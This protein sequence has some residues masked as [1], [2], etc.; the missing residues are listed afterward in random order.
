METV[1]TTLSIIIPVRDPGGL[2]AAVHTCLGIAT[3]S[4][5]DHEIILVNDGGGRVVADAANQLAATHPTV[6]VIHHAQRRGYTFALRDGWSVAR[7]THIAAIDLAG[8]AD[9]ADLTRLLPY[10]HEAA[11]VLAYRTDGPGGPLAQ[12][13]AAV[14]RR[15]LSVELHDPGLRMAIFHTDLHDAL[16]SAPNDTLAH[17]A[18]AAAAVRRGLPL[19]QVGVTT[20]G[21][22]NE[23]GGLS[24]AL[25]LGVGA[26]HPP[27]R[28]AVIG[29]M[30]VAVAGGLWLLRRR[31]SDGS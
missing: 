2:S 9:P 28:H 25:T 20:Q 27:Q 5:V 31:R 13:D 10:R 11:A 30:T 23:L 18:I 22:R 8:G 12:L 24:H 7:G 6:M 29:A 19:I 1:D 16:S 14:V 4:G 15:M 17:A 26:P 3:R 21:R